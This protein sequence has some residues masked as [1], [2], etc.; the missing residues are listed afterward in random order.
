MMWYIDA[1]IFV[2]AALDTTIKGEWSGD[3]IRAI[4]KGQL[5]ACTS[6]LTWDEFFLCSRENY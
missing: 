6:F 3:L 2:Y 1:N 5:K 4:E